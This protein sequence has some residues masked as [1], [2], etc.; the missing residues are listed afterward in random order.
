MSK[1]ALRKKLDREID[2]LP[3]DDLPQVLD[4]VEKL[5]AKRKGS[6]LSPFRREKLDPAKNPLRGLLGI[7]EVEPFA[8][9]I[10]KD[11]YGKNQ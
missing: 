7:A 4:L 11:L 6:L 8:H 9:R 1:Q 10:D 2:A 3:A 5:K